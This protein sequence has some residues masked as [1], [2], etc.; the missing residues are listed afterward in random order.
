MEWWQVVLTFLGGGVGVALIGVFKDNAL[1]KKNRKAALEDEAKKDEKA[2]NKEITALK[3]AMKYV[4]YCHI[5]T[6][7]Q[8]YIAAGEVDFDDRRILNDMHSVYHNDLGGN[9]DLDVLMKQVNSLPLIT[10]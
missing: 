8:K 3:T 2:E 9:G 1:W 5:R 4:L 10:K 6:W 7:G